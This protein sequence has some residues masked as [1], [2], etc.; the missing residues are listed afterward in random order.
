MKRFALV[1]AALIVA[2]AVPRAEQ[3]A[4]KP[5]ATSLSGRP[6]VVPAAIPN[7]QK[8]DA[9]LAQAEKDLAARPNDAEA[10]IWVGRRLGYL[11]RFNDAIAVFTKGIAAYP[12]NPKMTTRWPRPATGCG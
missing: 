5:E 9:D 6:L 1:M 8:L 2:M 4:A 10:M 7:K 3:A 12:D 11:W